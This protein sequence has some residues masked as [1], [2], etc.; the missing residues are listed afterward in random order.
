MNHLNRFDQP[1]KRTLFFLSVLSLAIPGKTSIIT[2]K[3]TTGWENTGTSG[4]WIFNGLGDAYSDGAAKFDKGGA[5]IK[6]PVFSGSVVKIEIDAKSSNPQPLRTLFI[7]LYSQGAEVGEKIALSPT[8]KPESSGYAGYNVDSALFADAFTV[9]LGSGSSGNWG[10]YSIR[11]HVIENKA[12]SPYTKHVRSTGFTAAWTNASEA[13]SNE[14]LIATTADIPFSADY[15]EKYDFSSITNDSGST[16]SVLDAVLDIYPE[17]GGTN[18]NQPGHFGGALMLGKYNAFGTLTIPCSGPGS[19][20]NLIFEASRFDAEDEGWIMPV[21]YAAEEET[22]TLAVAVLEKN[23]VKKTYHFP[24]DGIP[25]NSTIIIHSVTNKVTASR[26]NARTLVYSAGIA[27][28]ITDSHVE[29][30]IV[31]RIFCAG[32]ESVRACGLMP[33]TLYIWA[34]R[35]YDA[36]GTP[37]ALSEYIKTKTGRRTGFELTIK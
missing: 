26:A 23:P 36:Y 6:S 29:T 14:V 35:G 19:G 30:N 24:L 37:S 33:E 31:S 7:S 34:V 4:E 28:N 21:Y 10:V 18:V 25:D 3:E 2:E 1:M 9:E 27:G 20:K 8:S 13:V 5:Y 11:V 15:V 32:A 22:N 17:L 16:K 12:I